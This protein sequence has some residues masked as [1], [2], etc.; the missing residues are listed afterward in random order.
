MTVT[1]GEHAATAQARG[2]RDLVVA[3][4]IELFARGG[5]DGTSVKASAEKVGISDA[6]VLYH[7]ST[8]RDLF[9]AVVD[10]FTELRR[11]WRRR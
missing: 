1:R 4:A 2:T 6:G 10:V 8:K 7:F 9:V 11:P 3:A 5:Y